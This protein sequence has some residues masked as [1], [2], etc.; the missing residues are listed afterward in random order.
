MHGRD[1][2]IIVGGVVLLFLLFGLL[3]GGMMWGMMGPWMGG[4]GSGGFGIFPWA[5]IAMILFWALALI[6]GILLILWIVRQLQPSGTGTVGGPSR[7]L[8]ILRERYARGEITRDQF[9]QM[10]R[11]LE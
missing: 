4:P 5:G 11:D 2:A 7:S 8:E 1:V 9:E 3:G 6:G 10:R